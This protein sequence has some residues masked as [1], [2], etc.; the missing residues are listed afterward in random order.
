[1]TVWLPSWSRDFCGFLWNVAESFFHEN[2]F[3][4]DC[5][6]GVTPTCLSFSQFVTSLVLWVFMTPGVPSTS[7]KFLLDGLVLLPVRACGLTSWNLR[8]GNSDALLFPDYG[9]WKRRCR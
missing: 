4:N 3:R 5:K 7:A 1:M 9:L 2:C 8:I 6:A